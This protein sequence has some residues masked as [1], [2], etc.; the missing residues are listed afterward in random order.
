MAM[1]RRA[2][3]ADV[4][5]R[6]GVATSTVSRALSNPER[7]SA[8]T[9]A[10]VL[11][12]A[13]ELGYAA[14]TGTGGPREGTVALL[15]P[16]ITNPFYFDLIR[17]AQQQLKAS[18]YTQLLLDTEESAEVEHDALARLSGTARGVVLAAS[19]L[20]E[21]ALADAASR[22]P[23]VTVNRTVPGVSTVIVD[24]TVAAQ[25]AVEHLVS[26]GHRRIGYVG[27][28][29]ASWSN[30]ERWAGCRAAARRLGVDVVR[31]GSFAP[32]VTSG[33]GAADAL[34]NAGATAGIAFNDL[35]AIGMLQRLAA[36]RVRVPE[37]VS[38][39]G[40][41]D[42]FGADF[43]SPPLTTCAAPVAQAGRS[44]ITLLLEQID[45]HRGASTKLLRLST[46][47]VVRSSTGPAP[48]PG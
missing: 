44:A 39:V 16:D 26:L 28:P 42:I 24:S 14:P 8:P 11:R 41:D 48:K 9:R 27:G 12:A 5:R 37:E 33:A 3:L 38:V 20:T 21:T 13:R 36:R 7:V 35:I 45:A 17:G 25:Q 47:L 23:L 40:C 34:L 2:T 32:Q 31:L 22:L 10:L 46:H 1:V 19:R 15:V 43:C 4:A 18:G 6:A 29:E 30:R